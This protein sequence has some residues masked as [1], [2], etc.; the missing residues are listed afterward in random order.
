MVALPF[1]APCRS[2]DHLRISGRIRSLS[3]VHRNVLGRQPNSSAR[4]SFYQLLQ[5]V[6]CGRDTRIS[7]DTTKKGGKSAS[8][9]IVSAHNASV[10]AR[11]EL[12][13]GSLVEARWASGA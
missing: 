13:R 6:L 12:A 9:A 5:S 1:H 4:R 3:W 11:L 2:T 10:K 7:T 8:S